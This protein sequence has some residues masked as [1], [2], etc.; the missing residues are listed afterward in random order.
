MSNRLTVVDLQEMI[1]KSKFHQLFQPEVL[2]VDYDAYRL[3]IKYTMSDH[4]ERQPETHQWHGGAIAS[5]IDTT[6]CYCLALLALDTLPTENFQTD[7][8]RPAINT[9]LVAEA[10]IRKAGRTIAVVDVEITSDARKLIAVGRARYAISEP[11]PHQ[12]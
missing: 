10:K 1:S 3:A 5:I 9:D 8:L 2:E 6:G 7:Y 4:L 12:I 11:L